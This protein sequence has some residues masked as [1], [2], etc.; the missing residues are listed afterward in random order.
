MALPNF[1]N[2]FFNN[3]ESPP[4]NETE[5]KI[6]HLID[7]LMRDYPFQKYRDILSQHLKDYQKSTYKKKLEKNKKCYIYYI[8]KQ[9]H[10]LIKVR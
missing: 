9:N 7:F 4:I 6:K 5:K 1:L 10:Q 8:N 3:D 2:R